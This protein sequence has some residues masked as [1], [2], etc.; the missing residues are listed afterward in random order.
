[1]SV[2]KKRQLESD[3]LNATLASL[4]KRA[5]LLEQKAQRMETLASDAKEAR[6]LANYQPEVIRRLIKQIRVY[7]ARRIEIDLHAND[8]F[9]MEVLETVMSKAG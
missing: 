6:L 5:V 8:D 1:M 2:Q 4:E 3:N 7:E 9:I